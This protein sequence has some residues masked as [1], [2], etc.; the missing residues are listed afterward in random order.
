[1]STDYQADGK[2]R[3]GNHQGDTRTLSDLIKELRDES[4][5]LVREEVALAKT[6]MGEKVNKVGRNSAMLLAGAAVAHLGLIFILLAASAGLERF[7][8]SLGM[9]FHGDWIAPLVVGLIVGIIGTVMLLKARKTL[10][11]TTPV[12]ERTIESLKEDKQW[13]QAKTK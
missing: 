7:Y 13:L 10:S 5:A 8:D 9:W 12:P 4:V 1:M 3:V 11:E 6:E 2:S